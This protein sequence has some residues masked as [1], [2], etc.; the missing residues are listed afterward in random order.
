MRSSF[1]W[2]SG[3]FFCPSLE[4]KGAHSFLADRLLRIGLPFLL[5]A[6]LL[7]PLAHYPTYLQTATEPGIEAF[8]RHWLA[9]PFWASGPMWFL[10]LLLVWGSAAPG[11][12]RLSQGHRKAALRL[13]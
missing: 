7:M 1:F 11:L 4:R 5:I 8:W 2:M 10:W 12:H 9:L 3:W 13:A 6:L